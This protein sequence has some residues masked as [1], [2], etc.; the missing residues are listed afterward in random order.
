MDLLS[1]IWN[2]WLTVDEPIGTVL[3]LVVVWFLIRQNVWAWP[4]GVAYVFVSITV[5]YEARLYA[6]LLL[7]L[8]AFLPMNLYGWYYWLFGTDQ[9]EEL[10]VTRASRF[11][12]AALAVPCLAAAAGLGA[13]FATQTDAA[14]PF[15]DNGVFAMSLAA[16]WLT[17]RKKIE[18]WMLWFVVNVN[19]VA[20]YSL[21]G[22]GGYATLYAIYIGMAAWGY[23]TWRRSMEETGEAGS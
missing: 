20:L 6:N 23:V 13:W 17:A 7:H 22:L 12:L 15:W 11:V 14:Y 19:S 5:L 1:D 2:L 16:M 3:G 8:V 4:L 21:Q 10:P 18:N 9:G